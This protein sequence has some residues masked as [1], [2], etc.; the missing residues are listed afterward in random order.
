MQPRSNDAAKQP[1]GQHDARDDAQLI[2]VPRPQETLQEHLGL[3][4]KPLS[5]LDD[6]PGLLD[7]VDPVETTMQMVLMTPLTLVFV[8]W[9]IA[10]VTVG[11]FLFSFAQ[12]PGFG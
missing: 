4:Q 8:V 11:L 7:D 10:M 3:G 5:D 2:A 6:F 12:R 1:R 9:L